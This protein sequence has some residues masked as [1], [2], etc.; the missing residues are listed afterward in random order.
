M[1]TTLVFATNNAHKAKE[2]E[3]ILG[4]NFEVKTLR[5]IGCLEDIPET[6]ATLEG[7]A[8]LKARFVKE[9]YGFDCFS[10]DSGLEVKSLGGAPG[11]FSARYAGD[12]KNHDANIQFLL[13]NLQPHR[14]RSA[15][16]RAV[17]CLILNGK[18]NLFEG[19]CPGKIMD[20]KRGTGGFGYDPIFVPRG[21][22]K[23]FAELGDAVK[24][25]ISHRAISVQ[26]LMEFLKNN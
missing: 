23:T 12:E 9:K 21:R 10:D 19:I 22:R 14:D 3:Q 13:K 17:I 25:K 18:E 26:K 16:F 11:V 7:N 15:Q 6:A 2:V 1:K 24:N 20:E 4:K 5:D 8:Q